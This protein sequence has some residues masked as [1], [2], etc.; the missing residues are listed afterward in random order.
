MTVLE[1][2]VVTGGAGMIGRRLVAQLATQGVEVAVLDNLSSGLSLPEQAVRG[3]V[4]DIRDYDRV[5]QLCRAFRPQALVHL[6]AV[7][8]IPTCE[9]QRAYSLEVNVAG[10]EVVLA[11]AEAAGVENVVLASS[12]AVYAWDDAPLVEDTTALWSCDNYALAK[13]GNEVQLRFWTQRTGS[14]GRAA[15]IFNTIAHDDPNAHLIPDIVAQLRGG[16]GQAVIRLGNLAPRRDYVHADDVAS[17][18][19]ALLRDQ[20]ADVAFDVFNICSGDERSVE[21]LVREMAGLLGRDLLIEQDPTR[22]RKVDRLRQLGSP[23]KAATLL[24]WRARMSFREALAATVAGA[25]A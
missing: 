22:L 10:T 23:E 13:A 15:R 6:A 19:I 12:G 9:T 21:A 8:H 4:A 24:G 11:A 1:R 25:R 2:V 16:H 3:V 20:R 14:R 5:G 17:G 7:H 18:L